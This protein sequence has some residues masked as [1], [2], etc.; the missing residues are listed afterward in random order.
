MAIYLRNPL[1]FMYGILCGKF[2][3]G[4]VWALPN[5]APNKMYIIPGHI[6]E[7]GG[8]HGGPH[9]L[10]HGGYGGDRNHDGQDGKPGIEAVITDGPTEMCTLGATKQEPSKGLYNGMFGMCKTLLDAQIRWMASSG[11]GGGWMTAGASMIGGGAGGGS[12]F[13]LSDIGYNLHIQ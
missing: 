10:A 11:G 4:R 1:A 12:S 2:F 8:G 7:G 13:V 9:L 5:G 3:G 6:D